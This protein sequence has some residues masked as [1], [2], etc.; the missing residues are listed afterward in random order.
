MESTLP[1]FEQLVDDG[2]PVLAADGPILNNIHFFMLAASLLMAGISV[3]G[4]WLTSDSGW[5]S[6]PI[7]GTVLILP[8][9]VLPGVFWNKRREYSKRDAA[10]T[11]PWIIL[12]KVFITCIVVLSCKLRLPL[13][14]ELF[15]NMDH[16]LGFSVPGIMAW[17]SKHRSVSVVM[18]DSYPLLGYLLVS[19][20]LVPALAGKREAAERFLI[21][22]TISFL[23]AVPV[24]TLLPAIGP[25]AGYH[26]AASA[27]QK[28]TE[29]GIMALRNGGGYTEIG[30]I[31]CPSFHVIWAILSAVA[32]WSIKPLRVPSSILAVLIVAS[33]VTIGWHYVFDVLTGFVYV[34][35][36]LACADALMRWMNRKGMRDCRQGNCLRATQPSLGG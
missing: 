29:A 12:L 20:V 23:M 26:F 1:N 5:K 22:A 4:I 36:S 10:L 7:T 8:I 25:W 13:R 31:C 33:T 19:A 35:I 21:A 17:M 2:K 28:V 14:D 34:G 18:N 15:V 11:L 24:F 32:L 27:G 9:S 30:I 3:T 6:L 16:V